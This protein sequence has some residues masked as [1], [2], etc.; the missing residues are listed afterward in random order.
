MLPKSERLTKRDFAAIRPKVIFRGTYMDIA[1]HT[2]DVSKFACVISKKRIKRAV[3]RNKARRKIY[4]MIRETKPKN[5]SVIIIYPKQAVI[6][7]NRN[8]IQEELRQAFATL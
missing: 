6:S 3:D 4:H 7:G 5:P 1:A 8:L 2:S